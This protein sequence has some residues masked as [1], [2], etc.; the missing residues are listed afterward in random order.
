MIPSLVPLLPTAALADDTDAERLA[1]DVLT[2]GAAL[3]DMRDARAMAAT[4]SGNAEGIVVIKDRVGDATT[5]V[6]RGRS[7][8][9][10]GHLSIGER[11]LR[12]VRGMF[13]RSGW[14]PDVDGAS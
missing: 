9:G 6:F 4:D 14:S 8:I 13:D 11:R 7:A 12:V 10:R 3:F 2:S 1:Q 5:R